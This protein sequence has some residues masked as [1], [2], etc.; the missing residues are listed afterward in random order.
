METPSQRRYTVHDLDDFVL[1]SHLIFLLK[2]EKSF[3]EAFEFLKNT[4]ENSIFARNNCFFYYSI[5]FINFNSYEQ[6]ILKLEKSLSFQ[7]TLKG[8][9]I[10]PSISKA[11]DIIKEKF[12]RIC[13]KDQDILGT[14]ERWNKVSG[15]R[16]M[17]RKGQFPSGSFCANRLF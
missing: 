5:F 6:S 9:Q 14:P 11:L 3:P 17:L 16:S 4:H 10:H 7:V 1:V 2:C 15:S 13:L 12:E 8:N